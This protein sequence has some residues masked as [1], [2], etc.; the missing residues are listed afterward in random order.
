[1]LAELRSRS[2]AA[3]SRQ[4]LRYSSSALGLSPLPRP[5][6][7]AFVFSSILS[8]SVMRA[9]A[10]VTQRRVRDPGV[11]ARHRL[12]IRPVRLDDAE[13]R[14]LHGRTCFAAVIPE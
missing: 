7:A 14:L 8:R 3:E 5:F 6:A 13:R 10:A 12:C 2:E 4:A 11:L 1:M 9:R